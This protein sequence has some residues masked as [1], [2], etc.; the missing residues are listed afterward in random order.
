[1]F[2]YRYLSDITLEVVSMLVVLLD[3]WN[4]EISLLLRKRTQLEKSDVQHLEV[5]YRLFIIDIT[6][7]FY[8]VFR[9]LLFRLGK[10]TI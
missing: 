6:C 2:D 10:K 5:I 3:S 9:F 4:K 7:F 1:M 8:S